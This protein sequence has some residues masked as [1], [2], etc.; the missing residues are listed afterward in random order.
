VKAEAIWFLD[1]LPQNVDAA[2]AVGINAIHV[3]A[4]AKIAP[5]LRA[6]GLYG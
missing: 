1:D 6:E 4:F 3:K 2:R 5:A